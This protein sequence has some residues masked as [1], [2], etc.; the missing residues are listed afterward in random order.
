MYRYRAHM[1]MN[2]QSERR[3]NVASELSGQD[4]E[5][6]GEGRS[7]SVDQS[8]L[9]P[10]EAVSGAAVRKECVP[11]SPEVAARTKASAEL[12]AAKAR[13]ESKVV[14]SIEKAFS[15]VRRRHW[16][17]NGA[18]S[19]VVPREK[20]GFSNLFGAGKHADDYA[21]AEGRLEFGKFQLRFLTGQRNALLREIEAQERANLGGSP[22]PAAVL[23]KLRSRLERLV[24][25]YATAT[26]AFIGA[27]GI[28]R[29]VEA[30][31]P[32]LVKWDPPHEM[33][34]AYLR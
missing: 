23:E 9:D 21:Q 30:A 14:P 3:L 25:G 17:H 18:F 34:D 24:P 20:L 19:S 11:P 4:R 2:E 7:K 33:P 28:Y 16:V 31:N 32:A 29:R 10:S 6:G 12:A 13:L 15:D 8:F 22:P 27:T 1:H 26:L 5:E